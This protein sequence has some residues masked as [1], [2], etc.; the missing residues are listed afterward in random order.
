MNDKEQTKLRFLG[1]DFPQVNFTCQ[2]SF[3]GEAKIIIDITPRVYLSRKDTSHFKIVK[4]V[5]LLCEGYF[6]LELVAIGHFELHN[7]GSEEVRNDLINVNAPAIMFPYI[8][9]F[10]STFTSN[11][12][13]VTGTL[14]IPPRFFDG[15]L[16]IIEEE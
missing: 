6:E 11:L 15:D 13:N 4:D 10:I 7:V 14:N 1:V 16:P 9:S 5:K 12:G 3:N 8:R 2:N